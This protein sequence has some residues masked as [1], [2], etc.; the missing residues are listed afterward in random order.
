MIVVGFIRSAAISPRISDATT[1]F[2][3]VGR[4]ANSQII[5]YKGTSMENTESCMKDGPEIDPTLLL[6]FLI[7]RYDEII[8]A[9][10][11][12]IPV[13]LQ[14]LSLCGVAHDAKAEKELKKNLYQPHPASTVKACR[15]ILSRTLADFD[16][17]QSFQPDDGTLHTLD[18]QYLQ[19]RFV[20]RSPRK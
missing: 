16:A 2:V 13:V 6:K 10:Y 15:D 3:H 8:E 7:R 17:N 1:G 5:N 20:L 18:E 11:E 9:G 12:K 19:D 4:I 14:G